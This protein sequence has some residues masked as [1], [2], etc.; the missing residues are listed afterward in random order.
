M[1]YGWSE[2]EGHLFIGRWAFYFHPMLWKLNWFRCPLWD[3]V[4]VGP[5]SVLRA[6]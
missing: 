2:S 3:E 5:V 4:A 6:K 1:S